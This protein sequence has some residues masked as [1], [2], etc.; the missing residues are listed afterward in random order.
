MTKRLL[1]V[2]ALMLLQGC[3]P[4]GGEGYVPEQGQLDVW[5]AELIQADELFA[6]TIATEGLSRWGS[7][8]SPNGAVIREGVGEIQGIE[9][10]QASMD[11]VSASV[12]SFTWGPERA[13][14]S[15]SGDLGYTVGR[16]RTTGLNAEGVEMESTGMYVSVWRRQSDGEWKVE[17]DLGN[18]LTAPRPVDVQASQEDEEGSR[19]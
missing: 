18:P 13:E 16:Y 8:F 10:I 2:A 9:A 4:G 15:A 12:T 1:M 11:A 17:L 7:F 3:G 6:E 14:V 19:E 5:T